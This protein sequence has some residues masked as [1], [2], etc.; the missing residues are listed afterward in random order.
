L[1]TDA[2]KTQPYDLTNETPKSEIRDM[3]GGKVLCEMQPTVTL[4]NI[5]DLVLPGSQSQFAA[6]GV[7][8]LQL[9]NSQNGWVSTVV[10]GKVNVT[11]D[12]TDSGPGP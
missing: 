7:W 6:N 2:A 12:V 9:T 3:P 4:P 5:I 11:A 1:W 10:A 8:D